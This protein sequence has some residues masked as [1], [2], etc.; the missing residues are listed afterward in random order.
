[1]ASI[2]SANATMFLTIPGVYP[3]PTQ[4]QGFAVD[5]AFAVAAASSGASG[6]IAHTEV[7]V[8]G[9]GVGGF[10]PVAVMMTLKLLPSSPS[11]TVFENWFEAMV[12]LNDVLPCVGNISQPSINRKYMMYYGI[13]DTTDFLAT[14]KKT[15]QDREFK[16]S[17]LPQGPGI[18]AVTAAPF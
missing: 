17:W 8:D 6:G 16:I 7:G 3:A 12:A 11:V 9:F 5:D 4:I 18:P 15:L 1:M 2:T 14:A 13:F 10:V